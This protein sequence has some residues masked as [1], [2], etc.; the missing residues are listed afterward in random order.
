MLARVAKINAVARDLSARVAVVLVYVN[1]AHPSDVWP[2]GKVSVNPR[3]RSIEDR[4]R[5]ALAFRDRYGL[6]VPLYL[7]PL[8]GDDGFD[9][10]YGAWPDCSYCVDPAAR[11]VI[12][13][14]AMREARY[15]EDWPTALRAMYGSG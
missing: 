3:P 5:A 10:R 14:P 13:V 2:V 7:D 4:Q 12:F 11:K 1:E 9:A 8:D 6:E 15:V